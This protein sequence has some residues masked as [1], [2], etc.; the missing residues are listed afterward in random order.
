MAYCTAMS[1][2]G[3]GHIVVLVHTKL[4]AAVHTCTVRCESFL[5]QY[6]IQATSSIAVTLSH[7]VSALAQTYHLNRPASAANT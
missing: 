2:A 3:A 6:T 7:V 5:K 1:A 4:I